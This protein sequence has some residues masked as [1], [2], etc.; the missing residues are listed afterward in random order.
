MDSQEISSDET[1]AKKLTENLHILKIY[2][3]KLTG[4]AECAADLLQE[5]SVKVL[6]NGKSFIYNS[7]F[8]GWAST[9]MHNVYVNERIRSARCMN[10]ADDAFLDG[11]YR[12]CHVYAQEIAQAIGVLPYEHRTVFVMYVDGYKYN[13]IADEL[14]IPLGTVKSRIHIARIRLQELLKDYMQ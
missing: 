4:D 1:I 3:Y 12:D 6:S 13:E 9:I 11:E 10:V 14:N 5:T 2:A 7:N 8:K